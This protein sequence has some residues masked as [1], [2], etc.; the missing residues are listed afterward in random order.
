MP[1]EQLHRLRF[2]SDPPTD[3]AQSCDAYQLTGRSFTNMCVSCR[4]SKT[5]TG[6]R[7]R[8]STSFRPSA[9]NSPLPESADRRNPSVGRRSFACPR[10]KGVIG[11]TPVPG[12]SVGQLQV[13]VPD[14][15]RRVRKNEP[16]R[17]LCARSDAR[18]LRGQ[19]T[20]ANAKR[21]EIKL[22]V[23]A[24]AFPSCQKR[25][26]IRSSFSLSKNCAECFRPKSGKPVA[27]SFF[28][29]SMEIGVSASR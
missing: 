17:I 26:Q 2:R 27:N 22:L 4:K 5:V 8:A 1:P 13:D 15:H 7:V 10:R 21:S 19:R 29:H 11:S 6:P 3:V 18:R 16:A 25:R 20:K 14:Q 23:I 12:W 9:V 28:L 24:M